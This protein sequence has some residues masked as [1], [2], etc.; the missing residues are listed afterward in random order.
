MNVLTIIYIILYVIIL[1]IWAPRVK[2]F[3]VHS[4]NVICPHAVLKLCFITL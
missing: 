2:E 3:C 1:I 4:D